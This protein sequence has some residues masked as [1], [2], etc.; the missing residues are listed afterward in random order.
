MGRMWFPCEWEERRE[1]GGEGIP[2]RR[3]VWREQVELP[4]GL[5]GSFVMNAADADIIMSWRVGR[6]PRRSGQNV[7]QCWIRKGSPSNVFFLLF[8]LALVRLLFF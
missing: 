2:M 1:E 7:E 8:E 4:R 6:G 3:V 5:I